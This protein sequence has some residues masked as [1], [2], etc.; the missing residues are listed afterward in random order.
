MVR[1]Q[2]RRTGPPQPQRVSPFKLPM[3]T[4]VE[5]MR[6]RRRQLQDPE[7]AGDQAH[8]S[9]HHSV[10]GDGG[11]PMAAVQGTMVYGEGE[12]GVLDLPPER[13]LVPLFPTLRRGKPFGQRMS[14]EE[15]S[16]FVLHNNTNGMLELHG[17]EPEVI[18]LDRAV[19]P[20]VLEVTHSFSYRRQD[21][22]RSPEIVLLNESISSNLAIIPV[23]KTAFPLGLYCMEDLQIAAK[24]NKIVA[25]AALL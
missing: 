17:A 7:D 18:E 4:E 6:E 13:R 5:R 10:S 25:K 12:P 22:V 21:S 20:Q 3:A 15:L 11:R 23:I 8:Q 9:A 14:A 24:S 1:Y 19:S 16:Q 2:R